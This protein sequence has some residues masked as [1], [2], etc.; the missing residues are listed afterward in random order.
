MKVYFIWPLSVIG[1]FRCVVQRI[2]G[3]S[4]NAH[5]SLLLLE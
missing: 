3:K 5:V 4:Q 2:Q 1:K